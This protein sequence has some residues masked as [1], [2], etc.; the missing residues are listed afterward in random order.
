M[1]EQDILQMTR[2]ITCMRSYKKSRGREKRLYVA[3]ADCKKK[4]FDSVNTNGTSA[5][6][7]KWYTEVLEIFMIQVQHDLVRKACIRICLTP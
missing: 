3:F 2:Y 1:S 6:T 5:V 4:A 7:T